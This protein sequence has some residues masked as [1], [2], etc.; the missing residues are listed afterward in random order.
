MPA[1]CRFQDCP[2]GYL[3]VCWHADAQSPWVLADR[4]PPHGPSVL[5]WIPVESRIIGGGISLH[6][7]F[8]FFFFVRSQVLLQSSVTCSIY[9]SEKRAVGYAGDPIRESLHPS[10]QR[11]IGCPLACPGQCIL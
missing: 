5:T 6:L 3:F 1:M 2:A 4:C 7:F 10:L 8:F 9:D 11:C